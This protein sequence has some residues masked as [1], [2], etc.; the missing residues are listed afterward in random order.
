MKKRTFTMLLITFLFVCFSLNAFACTMQ[1]GNSDRSQSTNDSIVSTSDSSSDKSQ[2]IEVSSIILSET[3]IE[4]F[5]GEKYVLTVTIF[6]ENATNKRVSWSSSNRNVATVTNGTVRC[7]KSGTATITATSNNNIVAK[8]NVIVSVKPAPTFAQ[9]HID[10]QGQAIDSKDVYVGCSVSVTN[11][12][13]RYCF[14]GVSGKIKGRGNST[15]D[16][17]KKPYKLKFDE[18]VDLFGNG[19]AKTWTL[20]ANYCDPSLIRNHLVYA[21]ADCFDTLESTTK[22]FTVD[23]YL[24][25]VYNGVYLVCEQNET[26]TNRVDVDESLEYVDTGYLI[27]LDA[28]IVNEGIE[29]K[30]YFTLNG[31]YAIKGPDTEDPAFT[32]AH[33]DFIKAYTTDAYASLQSGD[34]DRVCEFLDVETFADAYVIHELFAMVDVGFSSFYM[35]KDAGGKLKAGP[36][37]DMDISSGNCDYH[38]DAVRT[39]YLW[40][41]TNPWYDKLLRFDEFR[42]LVRKRLQTFHYQQFIDEEIAKILEYEKAYSANFDVW[43]VLGVYVWP[44]TEKI[45][46]ITTWKGQ[47]EYLQQWLTAKLAFMKDE[48]VYA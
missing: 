24:N 32:Q 2:I 44:N 31:Y 16:M 25:G 11:T 1:S 15:W 13:E 7:L 18:K 43:D 20:I 46:S 9:M 27:E 4:A 12:D 22:I 23:L 29:G 34:F 41:K 30:D 42:S 6:P 5:E 8:C 10:T 33:F 38:P 26:G 19:L 14:E 37:W 36:L 28:R 48:Y 21:L 40:G 47:V 45:V 39:D 17:P 3:V 35:H